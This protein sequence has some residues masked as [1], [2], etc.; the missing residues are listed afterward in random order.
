MLDSIG[1][2]GTGQRINMTS[3]NQLV[4]NIHTHTLK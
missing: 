1:L 2:S 3:W 4:L